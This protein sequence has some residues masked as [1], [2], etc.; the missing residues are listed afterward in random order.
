MSGTKIHAA[1]VITVNVVLLE[2]ASHMV[3]LTVGLM[4]DGIRNGN[5]AKPAVKIEPVTAKVEPVKL[6]PALF[7]PAAKTISNPPKIAAIEIGRAS[8]R[9]RV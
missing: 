6:R 7:L 5:S 1:T 9:E 4:L 2:T 3:K 8:C